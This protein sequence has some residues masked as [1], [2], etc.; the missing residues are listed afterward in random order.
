MPEAVN[1]GYLLRI[2]VWSSR[3][4]TPFLP[5]YQKPLRIHWM[6]Q[7]SLIYAGLALVS[8]WRGEHWRLLQL[9]YKGRQWHFAICHFPW[10]FYGIAIYLV[11][12][13]LN[14]FIYCFQNKNKGSLN[15][16]Q[17]LYN[18][19][20]VIYLLKMTPFHTVDFLGWLYR[21]PNKIQWGTNQL[22][23]LTIIFMLIYIN[24]A[25]H[26]LFP[27][28]VTPWVK[29][30]NFMICPSCSKNQVWFDSTF[31]PKQTCILD[32]PVGE[33]WFQPRADPK[34]RHFP[35]IFLQHQG[36]FPFSTLLEKHQLVCLP[37]L[38]GLS[39][40]PNLIVYLALW[41]H[42]MNPDGLCRFM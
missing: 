19:C 16:L 10:K 5:D 32:F 11:W 33:E 22:Q 18:N 35:Q 37:C 4:V 25:Q 30:Q 27:K 8:I 42:Y 39:V 24:L 2:W 15:T 26:K 12:F 1:L 17:T 38:K 40:Q 13:F 9:L 36:A 21:Y 29:G 23:N 31:Q 34:P 20:L 41:D 14:Y 7:A 6:P 28:S 3:R